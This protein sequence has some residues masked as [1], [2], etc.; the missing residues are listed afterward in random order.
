MSDPRDNTFCCHA[1]TLVSATKEHN[2]L[3]DV[4]LTVHR[5]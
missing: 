4:I 1:T 3:F 2:F 5:R